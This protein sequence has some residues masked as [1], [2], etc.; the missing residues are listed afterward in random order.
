MLDWNMVMQTADIATL[1]VLR[2]FVDPTNSPR[3]TAE[4]IRTAITAMGV[5]HPL[6]GAPDAAWYQ[7]LQIVAPRLESR[8]SSG[9][10][11]TSATP[12]NAMPSTSSK[13]RC[14]TPA[15]ARA[16]DPSKA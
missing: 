14:Q 2:R 11:S 6:S 12:T 3:I 7:V 4:H 13:S 9:F 16:Q 15:F 1:F 10:C 8:D 5:N